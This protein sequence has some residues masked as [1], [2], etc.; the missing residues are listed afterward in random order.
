MI[1]T[2]TDPMPH[3]AGIAESGQG[4]ETNDV[5]RAY[6]IG[7]LDGKA[8]EVD[9]QVAALRTIEDVRALM[10]K[11]G[12]DYRAGTIDRDEFDRL[13]NLRD[14]AARGLAAAVE[15]GLP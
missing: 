3:L 6:L 11:A 14:A 8:D 5:G 4:E 1:T 10:D 9:R 13:L 15:I 12:E 2:P 7:Y